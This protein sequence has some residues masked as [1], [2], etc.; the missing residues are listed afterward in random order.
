ML[1]RD[2]AEF[3]VTQYALTRRST[4]HEHF[5][6]FISSHPFSNFFIQTR[7]WKMNSWKELE[8]VLEFVRISGVPFDEDDIEVCLLVNMICLFCLIVS[9]DHH[10]VLTN[11]L[12]TDCEQLF[13]MGGHRHP[14]CR[15]VQQGDIDCIFYQVFCICLFTKQTIGLDWICICKNFQISY[16]MFFV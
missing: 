9:F 4:K 5:K 16:W 11:F 10:I 13:G 6:S 1:F 15:P 8:A 7:K 3:F 12:W 2:R 14:L